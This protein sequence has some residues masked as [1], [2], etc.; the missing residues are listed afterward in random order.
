MTFIHLIHYSQLW[1]NYTTNK[2]ITYHASTLSLPNF[3][4]IIQDL[5]RPVPTQFGMNTVT[6]LIKNNSVFQWIVK[7][8]LMIIVS[9]LL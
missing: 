6:D 1:L 9:F 2:L 5:K 3:P 7:I 4:P 8:S